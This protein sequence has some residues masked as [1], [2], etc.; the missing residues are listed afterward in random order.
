[1]DEVRNSALSI[2][3]ALDKN[4]FQTLD[5]V[6]ETALGKKTPFTKRD[7][8]FVQTLVYGVLR[9]RSRIDWVVAHF[10]KT[11]LDKVD[12]KVLNILRLALFQIIYLSRVPTSAAVN[13]SVEMTKYYAAPWV[14]GYVNGLLRNVAKSY[15]RVPY[16]DMDKDP[17]SA[18][19]VKK[20]FPKWLIKRWLGRFGLNEIVSL[21]D[22]INT[23]PPIT[24]RTNTLKT[25]RKTLAKLLEAYT[26]KIEITEYSPD[27]IRFFSP[28]VPISEIEAYKH[29]H[30]QVQDE[31]SQLVSLFLNPQ[32]GETVLD[33]CAGLGGKTGHMAQLMKKRGTLTALDI[34]N[35]KL[36]RL[37]TEMHRLGIHIVDTTSHD[38]SKPLAPEKYNMFDRI[39]LDA[40]CSGL[41]VLRRHP[42][43]KWDSSKQNLTYHQKKQSTMLGNLANLVKPSGVLVYSV[44]SMEPEENEH[45]IK[46]FL[47]KHKEFVIESSTMGLPSKAYQRLTNNGYLKTMP[48]LHGMDGFFWVCL[49][50]TK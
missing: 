18:I 6:F 8:A 19:A 47:N 28:K 15:Q 42:D 3:N 38:L 4:R 37:K 35:K 17:V 31:A 24:V 50:R 14:A 12:P 25:N 41:G 20:S 43:A 10:S 44:C 2:L 22:A 16:P 23:I 33:A 11:R 34:D 7:R 30:F 13:T 39:L 5:T 29:G 1:L 9:W 32:P 36:F 49:K 48:H 26:E 40:P 21:C 46:G 27:G 45:V